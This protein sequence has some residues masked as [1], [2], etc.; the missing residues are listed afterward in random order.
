MN[1]KNKI[2]LVTGASKGIGKSIALTLAKAGCVVYINYHHSSDKAKEVLK[3][4]Q[5]YSPES[6]IIKANIAN[7]QEVENMINIIKKHSKKLDILVNNAGIVRDKTFKKMSL[8]QW[9]DVINTNLN[10]TFN[11]TKKALEIMPKNSN[12]IN[13]S[14][15]GA[16][17][18]PFG[19]S[20]YSASKAG[21]E[22]MTK[23]LAKELA[24]DEIRVNAIA[25]GAIDTDMLSTVPFLVKRIMKKRIPLK[26][27]GKPEN[28]SKAVMFILDND[29][30][31]GS[32]IKVSGGL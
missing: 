15:I 4:V 24:K 22:A 13:I 16:N 28:I 18:C 7:I 23:T 12:I 17:I 19:Q 5:N 29:Y 31:T 27:F 6:K 26:R 9:Y 3:L 1:F 2:A 25:P 14:S 30:V 10:G 8:N 20:N 11:V 32:I 21:I